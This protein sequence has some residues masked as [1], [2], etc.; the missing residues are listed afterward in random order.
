MAEGISERIRALEAKGFEVKL[1]DTGQIGYGQWI[2][3]LSQGN[4]SKGFFGQTE[5]QAI[6]KAVEGA[7]ISGSVFSSN[8]KRSG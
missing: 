8:R 5:S 7:A 6:A 2:C 1:T 4:K 3:Y